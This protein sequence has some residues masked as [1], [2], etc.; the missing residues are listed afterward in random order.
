M[1]APVVPLRIVKGKTLEFTLLYADSELEFRPITAVVSVAPLVLTVPGHGLKEDWPIQITGVK[2]PRQLNTADPTLS[3]CGDIPEHY[4]V[5]VVDEDTIR[6]ANVNGVEWP[7]YT[8]GGVVSFYRPGDLAGCEARAHVRRRV[9]DAAA[10]LEFA[11]SGLEPQATPGL[12]E[13]DV[14]A[15]SITFVLD[16]EDA[17]ELATQEAVWDAEL[18]TANNRV[19]P[20]VSISPC[21]IGDEVTR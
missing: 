21:Y 4:I 1:D 17:A 8:T 13:I 11:S 7:S 3:G 14:D 6:L 2:Q 5:R 15:S 18:V 19:R 10:I 12:I 9:N 20:L 16:A